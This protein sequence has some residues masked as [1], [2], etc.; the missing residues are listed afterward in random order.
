MIINNKNFKSRKT[1]IH[2]NKRVKKLL[3]ILF[4]SKIPKQYNN[5][6]INYKLI[7][8]LIRQINNLRKLKRKLTEIYINNYNYNN[9]KIINSRYKYINI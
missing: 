2:R 6:K 5:Y 9:I 8:I 1:Y 7:L 4:Y 3:I